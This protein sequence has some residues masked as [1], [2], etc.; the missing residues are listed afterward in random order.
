[1]AVEKEPVRQLAPVPPNLV[2]A[3]VPP[4]LKKELGT[5]TFDGPP[6]SP[7]R[8]LPA[9]NQPDYTIER[10]RRKQ[11]SPITTE[12]AKLK[13]HKCKQNRPF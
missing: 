6:P 5:S 4:Q 2:K 13:A 7:K 11:R 9:A 8:D 3:P 12:M 1:L 10:F